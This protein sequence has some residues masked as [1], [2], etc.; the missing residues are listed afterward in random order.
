[1]ISLS[2]VAVIIAGG[3]GT[4]FWPASRRALPKQFLN[5]TAAHS[6]I[7]D[8]GKRMAGLASHVMVACGE[9]HQSLAQDHLSLQP[10]DLIIEPKAKN[11]APAIALSV[12]HVMERFGDA[13][14]YVLPADHF[15]RDVAA[16]QQALRLARSAAEDGSIVTLGITPDRPETGY[17][18]IQRGSPL[19]SS[20][21]Q[22]ARFVEKPKLEDAKRYLSEGT[23]AW[24]AGI[25]VFK[26]SAMAEAL[27]QHA[28]AVWSPLASWKPGDR[29]GLASAFDAMPSISIDYA[30][31]EK[32]SNIKVIPTSCGWSDVGSWDALPEVRE[33][34]AQG[35]VASGDS[36]LLDAKNNIV[37][38]TTGKKVCLLGVADLIVVEDKDTL[39]IM[40]RGAG[41][42][43]REVVEAL[44][45]T[46]SSLI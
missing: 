13:I 40:P 28:P 4:R 12:R 44:E 1:M 21:F 45:K 7:A 39:L 41:Q 20:V 43:V 32:A 6:L 24:N 35:N 31:M 23:Y 38:N 36:L 30:V 17:G 34:D 22:V 11:T 14:M 16:F 42:R 10:N 25:F 3:S 26:A 2:N 19:G 8:T 29:A 9:R 46:G 5:L 33:A 18:Y 27:A 37:F 15:V